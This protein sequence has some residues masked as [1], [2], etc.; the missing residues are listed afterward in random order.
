M[1][2]SPN[3][4]GFNDNTHN[5]HDLPYPENIT[6]IEMMARVNHK[7]DSLGEID[8]YGSDT[9]IITIDEN[10]IT[11]GNTKNNNNI[12]PI[13]K[14]KL[15]KKEKRDVFSSMSRKAWGCFGSSS[16]FWVYMSL[17]TIIGIVS[18]S[19]CIAAGT[20]L[21]SLEDSDASLFAVETL[22]TWS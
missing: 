3:H 6:E 12:I 10:R 7:T 18:F 4:H 9:N 13:H 14:K 1:T 19:V 5:N 16:V 8:K 21:S 11:R 22:S 17:V 20:N 15:L 2:E